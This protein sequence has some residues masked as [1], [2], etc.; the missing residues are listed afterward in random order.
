MS[1]ATKKPPAAGNSSTSP[2]R[3]PRATTPSSA[4]TGT[5]V[6]GHTRTRSVRANTP[7][8]AR[9][10]AQQRRDSP[11]SNGSTPSDAD[12]DREEAARAETIALLD[13]LKERLAKAEGAS[14][15]YKKTADVLQVR[16]DEAQAEQ[17]R[18][19]EKCHEYEEQVESLQNE[20][21]EA[22][23]QMREME[24]I[25]EA[26][27]SAMMKEKED[28]ANREEE[29]QMIIQR[30]KDSLAQ[31][32]SNGDDELRPSRH[33]KSTAQYHLNVVQIA[34]SHPK[35]TITPQA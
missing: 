35:R 6:N 3:P 1:S 27:R 29:M 8:T 26:E 14:E 28:M 33:C 4:A 2:S 19:E 24:N 7:V 11:L 25:Y 20:R 12:R 34:D 9:A 18:L 32:N 10:A 17:A 22:A 23:R 13:D 21:R 5:A 31:R 16:L 30:L 15:S